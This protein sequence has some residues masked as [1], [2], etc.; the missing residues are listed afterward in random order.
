ML[1][2]E[3]LTESKVDEA[4]VGLMKRGLAALGAKLGS[5]KLKGYGDT[6]KMANALFKD[7]EQWQGRSGLGQVTAD[8]L[9]A[10]PLFQGDQI[11]PQILDRMNAGTGPISKAVLQKAVLDYAK[12]FNRTGGTVATAPGAPG[13]PG[14]GG[15]DIPP[16]VAAKLAKDV[17]VIDADPMILRYRS[18]DYFLG[19]K[20]Q[21]VNAKTNKDAPAPFQAFLNKQADAIEQ[22]ATPTPAPKPAAPAAPAPKP[23]APKPAAP[24]PAPKGKGKGAKI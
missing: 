17:E 24:K 2:R 15:A 16:Q 11:M 5:Q 21:W 12:E 1:I 13:A 20:G 10:S 14:D 18:V 8:D 6:A 9:M 7:I 23:A 3:I 19:D 22:T 4:P